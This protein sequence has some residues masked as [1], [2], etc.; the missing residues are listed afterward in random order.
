MIGKTVFHYDIL[1]E[2]GSGGMGVVYKARDTKLDRLV[3]LKFLGQDL[4]TDAESRARFLNEARA[5][6]NL[7]HPSIATIHAIEE[8][9]DTIFISLGY[10]EGDTLKELLDQDYHFSTE[11]VL[12]I[13]EQIA[14]GLQ[15]A[16]NAGIVHRDV[17][18]ANIFL[19]KNQQV[20]ILDFGLS[21]MQKSIEGKSG[22]E[23]RQRHGFCLEPQHF[24]DSP[25]KSN[26]PSVVLSPDE[27]YR[28][29]S[30]YKFYVS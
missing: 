19:T 11:E 10:Y 14:L 27:Q 22:H 7:D 12:S 21:K 9:E 24:P 2:I 30:I 5:I 16:H 28:Q 15:E 23:Y 29:T 20:K 1:A 3:A 6:S 13:I 17:K 8:F 4:T 25:H 26:F 18:P